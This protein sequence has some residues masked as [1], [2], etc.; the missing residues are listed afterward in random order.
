VT[1]R[2]QVG[3]HSIA[4]RRAGSGP[5]LVLLH[6]F[7]CDSR[8]WRT[9]LDGLADA[10]DVIAWDAPGAGASSDPPPAFTT[11]DWVACL[12]GFLDAIGVGRAHVVGLSWGGILAQEL[13]RWR[14]DRIDRLVLAGTYA[15]WR[16]SLP[17]DACEARLERCELDS[18]LPA[19]EL[20]RRWVP[21]MFSPAASPELLA[22]MS[23]IFAEF[24][25]HAFRLMAKSSD[26]DT[27]EVLMRIALPTLLLWGA[28]D[29][30]SPPANA[31]HMRAVLPAAELTIIQDAG[32]VSNMERP[33]AF[34]AAVRAFL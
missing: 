13:Y 20:C 25:P 6:G 7:L 9:Q 21:E 34:N 2:V 32:H 30:R 29:R 33:E 8:V 17:A 3:E 4:Y 5:P 12:T 24:H 10:F 19:D 23:A 16:G 11:A 26:A 22:E 15:G 18:L 1:G 27:T 14:P 31:H 28:Q